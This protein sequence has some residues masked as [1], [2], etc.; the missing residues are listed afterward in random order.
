MTQYARIIIFNDKENTIYYMHICQLPWKFNLKI[1]RT[2]PNIFSLRQWSFD[3]AVLLTKIETNIHIKSTCISILYIKC[4]QPLLRLRLLLF[5]LSILSDRTCRLFLYNT[6]QRFDT[7]ASH[8][9]FKIQF[10][11]A[12][13]ENQLFK[14]WRWH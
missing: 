5:L 4:F 3:H 1:K 8:V 12:E 13:L 10:E 7:I 11:Y 14:K 9:L 6:T 2:S